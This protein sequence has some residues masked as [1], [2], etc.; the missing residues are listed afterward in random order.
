MNQANSPAPRRKPKMKWIIIGASLLLVV[1]IAGAAVAN[2]KKDR[3]TVV[4][5]EKAVTK[6]ITQVV[7][8]TGKIRPE[9]EVKISPEVAGEI[10]ELPVKEGQTVRRG[11]LLVRIKPDFYQAQLEQQQA[12]LSSAQAASVLSQAR[13][14][15]AEEDYRQAQDLY[16]KKLI[17]DAD[18]LGMLTNVEVARADFASS[19]AQI[20]RAEGSV[21]QVADQLSKTAIYAPMDG[22]VSSLSSE[23][24]ERVVGT[25]QFAGTEI[26]R[27]ANLGDMEVRVKVNE[28]DIVN[29]KVGDAARITVDAY[30]GRRFDG[31][32]KEI[33][34]AALTVGQNTQEEVTN[35]EVRVRITDKSVALRPG[36]SA[37]TDIE[38]RTVENVIAV[39]IQ[40]VTVRSR[41][42]SKT[43]DQLTADREKKARETKGDGAATAV[44]ERQQREAERADRDALQRVVFLRD[45][46]KVKQVAVETGI[47]DSTHM[48]IKSGL[49]AGDEVVSG[50][51]SVV[52][53]TLKDGATIRVD[54]PKG[55]DKGGD[56]GKK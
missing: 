50:S 24:G 56:K 26:M 34:S 52:T 51:F 53:R 45:G 3:G 10:V 29:V 46:D 6:T 28:N 40:A 44:N 2:R 19:Q 11:D 22:T 32:V 54:R 9:V 48:E 7:T 23:A 49:K 8:A 30:P 27:V 18:Y 55:G 14:T 36:M 20:R 41:E 47:A 33:A 31:Q 1:L 37:N 4:T 16:A 25:G 13:L 5:T 39:P 15:K 43:I 38:T 12:A 35:F 17:S 21:N 42:G